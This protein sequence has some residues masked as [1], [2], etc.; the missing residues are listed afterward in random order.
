M[1]AMRLLPLSVLAEALHLNALALE[2][3]L[4]VVDTGHFDEEVCV[5]LFKRNDKLLF[6][7]EGLNDVERL[8]A[9]LFDD[10]TLVL[11]QAVVPGVLNGQACSLKC[12]LH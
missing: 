9:V 4:R 6:L 11:L 10:R 7:Q 2:V 12:T 1:A 8:V 5:H 3:D